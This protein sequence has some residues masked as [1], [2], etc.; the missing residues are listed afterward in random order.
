MSKKARLTQASS[1]LDLASLIASSRCSEARVKAILEN[2]K[3]VERGSAADRSFRRDVSQLHDKILGKVT[4]NLEFPVVSRDK[5][6]SLPCAKLGEIIEMFAEECPAFEKLLLKCCSVSQRRLQLCVYADEVTPGD[7][8][9]PDNLR[10]AVLLYATLLNFDAF[11]SSK[12]SWLPVFLAKHSLVKEIPGGLS[13]I[14]RDIFRFWKDS[15][16]FQHG[17]MLVLPESGEILYLKIEPTVF[18]LE[19][20]AASSSTWFTK[21]AS[22]LLPCIW[23]ANVVLTTSE[24][25]LHDQWA[26][27]IS[28][29]EP[30]RFQE[31][32]EADYQEIASL[33]EDAKLTGALSET[34]K[35]H[36]FVF[37]PASCIAGFYCFCLVCLWR[38]SSI[39]SNLVFV[40]SQRVSAKQGKLAASKGPCGHWLC[41][42]KEMHI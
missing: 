23:C 18:T 1:D 34:E 42:P 2:L 31:R 6:E 27:P 32:E 24:L 25:H 13:R 35:V 15:P 39:E 10:Q 8:F 19:D 41:K 11:L 29:C 30:E 37:H 7:V 40:K 20:Y 21:T 22:G 36:G 5:P 38:R 14:F 16:I 17:H 9:K 4:G 28:C 3:L 26:V 33:L 12:Y